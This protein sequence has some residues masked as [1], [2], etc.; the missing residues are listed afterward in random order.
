MPHQ[1]E[2]DLVPLFRTSL[3]EKSWNAIWKNLEIP[4]VDTPKS[5]KLAEPEYELK[6]PLTSRQGTGSKTKSS[7]GRPLS[8]SRYTTI[9]HDNS[10]SFAKAATLHESQPITGKKKHS[11]SK[12]KRNSFTSS[13]KAHMPSLNIREVCVTSTI[14]LII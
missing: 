10:S 11:K 7:D 1:F 6:Y 12:K 13:R 8:S 14:K 4:K 5:P 3:S 9:R 2:I